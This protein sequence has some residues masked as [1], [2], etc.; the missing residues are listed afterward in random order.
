ML[1]PQRSKRGITPHG[2]QKAAAEEASMAKSMFLANMSHEI[3]TPLNGICSLLELLQTTVLTPEQMEVTSCIQSS[4][5][6]L[7][8]VLNDTLDL[9]K[10]ESRKL[11]PMSVN[12][13]PLN[14]LVAL[15][16]TVFTKRRPKNVEFHILMDPEEPTLYQGDAYCFR[17]IVAN[18]LS[19]AVKFTTAG[20]VDIS[21]KHEDYRLKTTIT[22]TGLGMPEDVLKDV[23]QHFHSG[24]SMAVYDQNSV[25]IGLSLVTEMIRL[26]KGK[27]TVTTTLGKGT[28]FV[29]ELPFQP[30]YFPLKTRRGRRTV[31]L[32]NYRQHN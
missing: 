8:E 13:E 6:D 2:V 30:V 4:F 9:V 19:N 23:Q 17:R 24:E 26:L 28:T 32:C 16:D 22:D 3:R 21:I 12:F 7:S 1:R 29:F 11:V 25:G 31:L 18:L 5:A 20:R 14:V 27:I 10:L 15:Q